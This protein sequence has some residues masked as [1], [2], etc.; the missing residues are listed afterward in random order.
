VTPLLCSAPA[1]INLALEV[2]GILPDGYHELDTIFCW[3]ELEDLLDVRPSAKTELII[4]DEIGQGAEV[5]PD[6]RN[7]VMKALRSLE[8]LVGRELPTRLRLIKRIPAGGGLGGGSADAAAALLGVVRAHDLPLQPADLLKLAARLGAD[9]AFGLEGGTAR[10]RGRG[11]LLSPLPSPPDLPVL[12]LIPHF[13]LS[14]PEVYDCWDRLPEEVRRPGRGS[15]ERVVAAL[16][17][18]RAQDLLRS[19]GNDLEA[20]AEA[21]RPELSELRRRMLQAGCAQARLCGSGSTLFGLLEPSC[22]P[23]PVATRL[24]DL[25]HVLCTRFRGSPR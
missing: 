9:V 16:S 21:L 8:D 24:K 2:Q 18:G 7:L 14:T 1:K 6:E 22:N 15:A 12:L 19:T 13:P 5:V 20:A 11:E 23:E 4:Q 17:K 10:G 25:G 3:L